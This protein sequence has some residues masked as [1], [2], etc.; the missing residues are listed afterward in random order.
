MPF[1]KIKSFDNWSINTVRQVCI[2]NDLYTKGDVKAYD[3]MLDCVDA[4]YPTDENIYIV[5]K[6]I[7]EHSDNQPIT[8]V[9]YMLKNFAVYTT[10]TIDGRD[11]I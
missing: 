9:M 10:F 11:D 4:S 1:P 6:D 5:A 7:A 2:D 8:N 3:N